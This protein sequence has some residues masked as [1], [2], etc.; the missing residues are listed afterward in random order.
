MGAE[1]Q[2]T[3]APEGAAP[4]DSPEAALIEAERKGF[5]LAVIGRACALAPI[6]LFYLVALT[7]PNDLYIAGLVLFAAAVGLV[8]LWLAG[9]RFE[10]AGRYVFFAFDAAAISAMLV[11][12]PLTSGGDVPQNFVF[13]GT[14]N[15]FYY[16][17]VAISLLTLSPALVLWTGL[18]SVV[19][20][21]AATVWIASGMERVVGHHT[22]P[23]MPSREVYL[24]TLLSLDF[25]SYPARVME[26]VAI[27]VITGL[28][29]LVVHRARNMVRAHAAEEAKRARV[30]RAFGRYVPSQVAEQLAQ[31]G[32]LAPQQRQASI[33][34]AD[35]EGFTTLSEKL[36]PAEVIGVLNS[37]FSAASAIIE[38]R[39]G[40]IVN[41]IGDALMASFNAPLPVE[42]YAQRAVDAARALLTLVEERR[43]EGH[44]LRLRIGVTTGTVAAGTVGGDQRQTY[45]LYGDTVN[46]AQR[47]EQLNKELGSSCLICG[48]TFKAAKVS[49]PD[50]AP[51]RTIQVRGREA[52]VE[53]FTLGR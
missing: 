4:G 28:A 42:G 48:T 37:F 16:I 14:R 12:S 19:G 13:L 11:F 39:G 36:P 7:F 51:A 6:A 17:V 10:R 45:T 52:S 32:H 30:Q 23:P 3:S 46:L 15:E 49:S 38:K 8:Q 22:L 9:G 47:L 21:A 44:R 20:L 26:A 34:F 35:I 27:L 50:A 18:C 29:A 40:I 31:E 33:I 41:H 53:V 43:F 25:L 5:R 24:D 2:T 1:Q